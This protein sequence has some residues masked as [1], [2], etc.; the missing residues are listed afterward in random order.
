MANFSEISKYKNN[1]ISAILE[2]DL[3]VRCL[4]NGECDFLAKPYNGDKKNLIYSNIFPWR[5][6][7]ATQLETKTYIT[8]EFEAPRINRVNDLFKDTLI[9]IYLFCHNQLLRTDYGTRIDWLL[10]AIDE[11]FNES[12]DFGFGKLEFYS[13]RGIDPSY[14]HLGY[15]LSYRAVDANNSKCG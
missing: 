14:D 6:L 11:L 15:V 5:K 2:N 12:P 8:M 10:N 13:Y 4:A 1:I 7:P 3:I 9:H